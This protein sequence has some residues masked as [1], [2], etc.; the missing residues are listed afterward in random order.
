MILCV[1]EKK[2]TAL[3]ACQTF[4]ELLC[5]IFFSENPEAAADE[6]DNSCPDAFGN[7][8]IANM[9]FG[10]VQPSI[11]I[12][13]R[14]ARFGSQPAHVMQFPCF[15]VES[16]SLLKRISCLSHPNVLRYFYLAENDVKKYISCISN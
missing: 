15:T 1:Q 5:S 9:C 14:H 8:M 3:N 13:R 11:G 16:E 6:I 10:E 4:P 12:K 2:E 7:V